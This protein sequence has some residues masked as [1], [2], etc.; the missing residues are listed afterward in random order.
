MNFTLRQKISVVFLLLLLIAA[1]IGL[2]S[3]QRFDQLGRSIDVILR[4]NYRSVIA[5][6]GMNDSLERI[7]S[8][9]L[10]LLSGFVK[11]GIEQIA[12]NRPLFLGALQQE[13]DNL[14]LP[15]E[16]G[17]A[18]DLSSLYAS[19]SSH[20]DGFMQSPP[21]ER[22]R[23]YFEL[24]F[25][26]F[27]KIKAQAQAI[28]QMNQE[29]MNAAS[30]RARQKAVKARRDMI[31]LLSLSVLVALLFMLFS[32]HWILKPIRR[33]IGSTQEIRNGNLNLVIQA[34]TRDEIG[35]LSESFNAMVASLRLF[36]RSDQAK[37]LRMQRSTQEVFN[38]LPA[39]IA[40]LDSEGTIEIATSVARS[41]FGLV[42]GTAIE[43]SPYPWLAE[44]QRTAMKNPLAPDGDKRR[45]IIQQ[46]SD[47]QEKFFK[48]RVVPIFNNEK[49]FNGSIIILED[50]T[51]LLQSDEIKR[52]LFSTI[53]HQ[54]KTPLTSIRMALHLLLDENVGSLNEKQADLLVS[55]RDESERLNGIIEDLLDIRRLESGNVRLSLAA[56]S[57]H[58]LVSEAIALFSRQAQDKGIR[59]EADLPADLP[60][61]RADRSRIAYVFAN[62]LSNAIKYSP[63]GSVVRLA[64]KTEADKVL[65]SVTDAGR[66]IPGKYQKRIFEKFFRVPGKNGESGVGLGLSIAKEILT[67]H[68]GRIAFSSAEGRGSTFTFSLEQQDDSPS[69]A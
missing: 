10:F 8:G 1:A 16:A 14:T 28:L 29:N 32:N 24:L 53:S 67:A 2:Q 37:L 17:R 36:R 57:P 4:E 27:R 20:L 51:L 33:L 59:I 48:P 58:E 62:L 55:A 63:F 38:H 52:D 23:R 56:V 34:D 65:F 25:P 26:L 49:E 35:Q 45:E 3:I 50:V 15:G 31:L 64:A 12:A 40:I 43:Q 6:Q 21:A 41:R 5:C 30:E 46:F 68:G 60:R 19:Y 9:L 47:N 39:V 11:E 7:D 42:P 18:R 44:L 61:V 13:L 54:L 69:G 66:G 22:S